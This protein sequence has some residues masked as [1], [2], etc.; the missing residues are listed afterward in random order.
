M[1]Y[2]TSP[3]HNGVSRNYEYLWR[4]SYYFVIYANLDTCRLTGAYHKCNN[5]NLA[6]NK[7]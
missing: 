6:C 7:H 4:I 3:L 1:K 2:L 5:S